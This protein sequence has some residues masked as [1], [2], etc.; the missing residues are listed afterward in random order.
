MRSRVNLSADLAF[1]L[2]VGPA[3]SLADQPRRFMQ[4]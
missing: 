4:G 2:V 1:I 3:D